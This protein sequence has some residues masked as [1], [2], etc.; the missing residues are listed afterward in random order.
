[1][2]WMVIDRRSLILGSI[3]ALGGTI[4][5]SRRSDAGE[6]A[7]ACYAAAAQRLD[8][9][10]AVLLLSASGAVVREIP[11]S[12]RG[13]DIAVHAAS[14]RAVAFA[15]RPGT[16]AV[17]FNLHDQSPPIVFDAGEGR[18]FYGHGVFSTDGRLLY[19]TEND[20]AQERG[21]ISV[22]DVEAGYRKSGEFASHGVGPHD[23]L[24]LEDGRTL[25]IANGG[26]DTVPDSGRADLNLDTM[27]PSL[28]FVDCLSGQLIAKHALGDDLHRLSIRHLAVST[29]GQVWFG[30]QWK[31]AQSETP[32]LVGYAAPKSGIRLIAPPAAGGVDLKGYI[33][34]MAVSRDG[35]IIAASAPKAGRVL[36]VDAATQELRGVTQLNDV[37][38]IAGDGGDRFALSNG[39]GVFR[40]E[41]AAR[42]VICEA[43]L[44]DIAFDNHL[45]R[46]G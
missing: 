32:Q 23:V 14:G 4:M 45:R 6:A 21:V 15:R 1:M 25:A 43:Q 13:H 26:I 22:Y 18:H 2:S 5:S 30:G 37:C 29:D 39:F 38:G 16:F 40:E 34:S 19:V 27:Q 36:Y 46:W 9:S 33:G 24:L 41:H 12:A 10:H 17:A 20:F 11:L 31:G 28:T 3:V 35:T 42:S 7:V 44:A 8:G